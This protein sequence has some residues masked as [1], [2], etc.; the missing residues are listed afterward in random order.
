MLMLL[1]LPALIVVLA[2]T[3]AVVCSIVSP[4]TCLG[5]DTLAMT[6]GFIGLISIPAGIVSYREQKVKK[7][8]ASEADGG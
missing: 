2:I 8:R 4:G 5:A 6:F 7:Q 3:P 1:I